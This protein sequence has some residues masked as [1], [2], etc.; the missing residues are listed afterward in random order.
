M[1][2]GASGPDAGNP[3]TS[4]VL[5]GLRAMLPTASA[6]GTHTARLALIPVLCIALA[7]A[8]LAQVDPSGIDFVT[9]GSPGNAP[10]MGGGTNQGHGEV[11]YSYRIGRLEVTSQQWCEFMNAALDR[12]SGDRIPHVFAPT[13][14]GA[15]PTTP[16][17]PGG[18]RFTVPAGNEMIPVGG[19]DWRTSAIFCNWLCA[20]KS[21]ARAGFLNGAYDVS[22]FGWYLNG[23]TF[24]DQLTHN[25]GARY[26]IPTLD[27]WM[28][29]AHYDPSRNGPGQGGWWTYSNS[30]ESPYV[31]GPP[32]VLV[33]GHSTT[34]NAAWDSLNF[35]GHDPYSV[36][37][38][39]FPSVTSPWG[40][41][42]TAGGTSEWTEGYIRLSDEMF[43]R[44]RLL[45]GSSW[46]PEPV[47]DGDMAGGLGNTYEPDYFGFEAGLRI[48]S[49]VP[50]PG[51]VSACV[52]AL[53]MLATRRRWR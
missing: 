28:K 18:Q 35:P 26:W 51:A 38:G 19:V 9:V 39:A 48:A 4:L 33:N 24:T 25:A 8:A 36:A 30:S 44:V 27:E 47:G 16:N 46:G 2:F 32:G 29:A 14:W 3:V 17:N 15:V 52:G 50:A 49:S 41:F 21:S 23:P 31:Y 53:L 11:D 22:T 45:G 12:P 10:W 5:A 7:P 20:D 34:A 1:G 6:R 37:L 13:Q 40:L 43:P 42:D